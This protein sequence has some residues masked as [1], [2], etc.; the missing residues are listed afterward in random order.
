MCVLCFFRLVNG[1]CVATLVAMSTVSQDPALLP[2]CEA[3]NVVNVV[4]EVSAINVVMV[5]VVIL[6]MHYDQNF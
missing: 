5:L 3:A 2:H 6:L 4:N 1:S